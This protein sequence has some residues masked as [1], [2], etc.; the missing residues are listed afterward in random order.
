MNTP[1]TDDGTLLKSTDLFCLDVGDT[2]QR[3]DV[4]LSDDG[5]Y[6]EMDNL[7]RLLGIRPLGQKIKKRGDWFRK[8]NKENKENKNE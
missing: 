1:K 6:L 4:F 5:I 7:G 8:K 2:I 3:G